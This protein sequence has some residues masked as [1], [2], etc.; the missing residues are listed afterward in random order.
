[1]GHFYPFDFAVQLVTVDMSHAKTFMSS[2]LFDS[3][4]KPLPK[5]CA[6]IYSFHIYL[7]GVTREVMQIIME[8]TLFL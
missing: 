7:M 3:R 4:H 2:V 5:M 8:A 6:I 1:M